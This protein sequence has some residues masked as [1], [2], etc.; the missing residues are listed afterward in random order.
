MPND[1]FSLGLEYFYEK[2]NQAGLAGLGIFNTN[3]YSN[4]GLFNSVETH[5][6]PLTV[7]FFDTSGFSIKIKNSFVHQSGVFQN[8]NAQ[9]TSD[10]VS[11]FF[12]SDL[13]L[14]YRIPNRHGMISVGVNNLFNNKFNYQ[15]TD[16]N[17]VTITPGRLAFSKITLV[18]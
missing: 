5:R 1:Q 6:I 10:G 16:Y 17:D 18:F 15:N 12:V 9:N 14:S 3:A 4:L 11:D 13:N 2:I 8:L 7:N